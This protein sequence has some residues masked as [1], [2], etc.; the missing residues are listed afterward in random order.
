MKA[1][2]IS[3]THGLFPT[4][5]TSV[6]IVLHTGDFCPNFVVT[7]PEMEAHLQRDWL[8]RKYWT[9]NKWLRGRPMLVVQGNHDFTQITG[10][11]VIDITNKKHT[12]DN[13]NFYGFPWVPE[14]GP[15]NWGSNEQEMEQRVNRIPWGEIDVLMAHCPPKGVLDFCPGGHIGNKQLARAVVEHADDLPKWL[16][17]GHVHEQGGG[18]DLHHQM[19]ILNNAT[20]QRTVTL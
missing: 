19:T 15:W 20:T 14:F 5:D 2:H 16:L 18:T 11:G 17:C 7:D 4:L 8:K 1:L 12:I 6:D 13:L 3:D 9:I 10:P